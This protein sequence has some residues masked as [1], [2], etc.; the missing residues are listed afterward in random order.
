VLEIRLILLYSIGVFQKSKEVRAMKDRRELYG[1]TFINR[2]DSEEIVEPIKLSYYKVTHFGDSLEEESV[3]YGI[4]VVKEQRENDIA[5]KETKEVENRISKE[6]QAEA[7]LEILKMH[8]VT[9]VGLQDVL[10]DFK[11]A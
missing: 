3:T 6:A 5:M 10:D 7:L 11:R 2:T 9:P 1:E 4:E 8:K